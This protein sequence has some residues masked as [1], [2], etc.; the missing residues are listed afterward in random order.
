MTLTLRQNIIVHEIC[1][2]LRERSNSASSL[3]LRDAILR[4]GFTITMYDDA[5]NAGIE[6]GI[7]SRQRGGP[8]GL[9]CLQDPEFHL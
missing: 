8:G 5:L 7:V 1:S 2:F 4:E 6:A 3:E 9:I